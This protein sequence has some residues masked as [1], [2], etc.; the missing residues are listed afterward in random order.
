MDWEPYEQRLQSLA[1][2]AEKL[3]EEGVPPET[4]VGAPTYGGSAELVDREWADQT[5]EEWT[6]DNTGKPI[7]PPVREV[8]GVSE[9]SVEAYAESLDEVYAEGSLEVIIGTVENALRDDA[10]MSYARNLAAEADSITVSINQGHYGSRAYSGV[11]AGFS[12]D[13]GSDHLDMYTHM[14]QSRY[15]TGDVP[16]IPSPLGRSDNAAE[17]SLNALDQLCDIAES[18]QYVP[19]AEDVQSLYFDTWN[20]DEALVRINP[21]RGATEQAPDIPMSDIPGMNTVTVDDIIAVEELRNELKK[22]RDDEAYQ[23]MLGAD[24]DSTDHSVHLHRLNDGFDVHVTFPK[25][26]D[27]P[28]IRK[29]TQLK[30]YPP[31]II[32]GGQSC[33]LV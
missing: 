18:R 3:V 31:D 17:T 13:T 32:P 4:R 26:I 21:Q 33:P 1:E 30:N 25:V 29:W 14:L 23:Q 16:D 12:G 7:E 5:D 20:V 27:A 28:N 2:E 6:M 15:R 22:V 8:Y 9:E 10:W 19:E 11:N 24:V